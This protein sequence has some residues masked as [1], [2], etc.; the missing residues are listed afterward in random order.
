[1]SDCSN[2]DIRD[3]LPDLLHDRLDAHTRARAVAH[4]QDCADCRSE[5]ELLRSLRGSFD[6]GTPRVD[7][8]RVVAALPLPSST[9]RS[10]RR[11]VW[12][13]WRIAAAVTFFVAGGTS[14]AVIHDM[15]DDRSDSAASPIARE[16]TAA[17]S[18]TTTHVDSPATAVAAARP[19]SHESSTVSHPRPV[20]APVASPS[21][22][23]TV[24]STDDQGASVGIGNSR[25][26]D[27]NERQLKSLLNQIDRLEATPSTEPEPVVLR[28]GA[29][30]ASP[31]G[32]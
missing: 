1:M 13:D 28:V 6:R 15:R 3:L 21:G 16:A 17:A 19:A 30:T 14:L 2:A 22:T 9:R 18:E 4:V 7:V 12:S 31:P 24:A 27:L 29:R 26:G 5:L 8:D 10:T 23:Q 20:T 11:P 32:L 25:I